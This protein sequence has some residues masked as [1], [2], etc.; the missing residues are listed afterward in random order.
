LSMPEPA[1]LMV[2]LKNRTLSVPVER[3]IDCARHVAKTM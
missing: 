1:V 3:F 2:T